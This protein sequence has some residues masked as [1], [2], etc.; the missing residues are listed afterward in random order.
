[1]SISLQLQEDLNRQANALRLQSDQVEEA[2]Q[3]KEHSIK[4]AE[5]DSKRAQDG[6]VLPKTLSSYL[7]L[8]GT[9]D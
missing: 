3:E 5:Q 7:F 2:I 1:M 8:N 9:A 6:C 4:E